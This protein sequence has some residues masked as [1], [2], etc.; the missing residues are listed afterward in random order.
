MDTKPHALS[1]AEIEELASLKNIQE[2]WG[3]EN[4]TEMAEL[5]KDSVYAVK[6][7]FVSGAP[8]Y[9]DDY[10]IL[11]GDSLGEAVEVIRRDGVLTVI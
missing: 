8:G 7:N 2:M 1:N 6:F 11:Q 5:L 9:V 3:A 4:T 10:F